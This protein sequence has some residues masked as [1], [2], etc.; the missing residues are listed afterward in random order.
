MTYINPDG[1]IKV[2]TPSDINISYATLSRDYVDSSSV[3]NSGLEDPCSRTY[4]PSLVEN[5]IVAVNILKEHKISMK[6]R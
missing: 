5:F 2:F 6:E 1:S 3:K 4:F